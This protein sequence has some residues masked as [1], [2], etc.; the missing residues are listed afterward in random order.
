MS[1]IAC[2]RCRG[3]NTE[4]AKR[5]AFCSINL[6]W[7]IAN[8]EYVERTADQVAKPEGSWK[9]SNCGGGNRGKQTMCIGCHA[10]YI[11]DDE[12]E[13]GRLLREELDRQLVVGIRGED[14]SEPTERWEYCLMVDGPTMP[15]SS[16]PAAF[17]A[18]PSDGKVLKLSDGG[19]PI[20]LH[21]L[22]NQGWELVTTFVVSDLQY[23]CPTKYL[24][25][26]WS[27]MLVSL[28]TDARPAATLGHETVSQARSMMWIFKRPRRDKDRV[29]HGNN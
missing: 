12:L 2:P 8:R 28:L 22:G 14:E 7:A 15:G 18:F 11:P 5:C 6:Q 3:S 4:S 20:A 19:F 10:L 17:V 23:S 16:E 1:N 25:P 29:D 27:Y 9:C 24:R 26:P 21:E 13:E